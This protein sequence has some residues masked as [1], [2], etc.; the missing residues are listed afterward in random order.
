M[1]CLYC[2]D[3]EYLVVGVIIMVVLVAM[4][5]VVMMDVTIMMLVTILM[6]G[7]QVPHQG[8]LCAVIDVTVF[9]ASRQHHH[10]DQA[11]AC[12]P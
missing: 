5:A 9:L 10:A 7:R 1:F 8:L 11:N 3:L 12:E 2:A 6:V 4:V